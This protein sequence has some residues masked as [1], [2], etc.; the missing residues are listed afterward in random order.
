MW[1]VLLSVDV[2]DF[3]QKQDAHIQERLRRGLEKLKCE[4]PFHYLEHY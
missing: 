3:L 2:Q 1:R 4:N